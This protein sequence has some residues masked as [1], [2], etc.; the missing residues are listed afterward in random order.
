MKAYEITILS[1]SVS[2]PYQLLNQ[3]VYF[4]E[5]QHGSHAIEGDLDTINF[6]PGFKNG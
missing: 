1:V 6:K 4:Y 2:P 3:L 5:I